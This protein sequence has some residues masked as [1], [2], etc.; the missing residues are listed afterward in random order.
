MARRAV[1][2]HRHG[3]VS[4]P[5]D[6]RA[7]SLAAP[8]IDLPE[9]ALALFLP[10]AGAPREVAVFGYFDPQWRLLGMRH[11]RAEA[12]D[13]VTIPLRAVVIDALAFECTHVVMA[14]NHPSGDPSPSEADYRLTRRV[15]QALRFVDV[16]LFDHLVVAES[17]YRSFRARGLL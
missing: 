5:L 13:T 11:V 14:H 17:G 12:V 9:S 7:G 8:G 4:Q 10:I 15:A 2:A 16:V 3:M 1:R 6:R